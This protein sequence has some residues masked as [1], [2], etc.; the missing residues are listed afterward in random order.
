MK[1]LLCALCLF[2]VTPL[3]QG[4]TVYRCGA[5]GRSYSQQPCPD[6]RAV[7]VDDPRTPAQ[8]EQ[9][10]DA[11]RRDARAAESL[12]HERRRGEAVVV[13][14]AGLSAPLPKAQGSPATD[15]PVKRRAKA[16]G[17]K[18]ASDGEFRAIGP[19]DPAV[20]KKSRS[21]SVGSPSS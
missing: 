6:G 12:A 19:A 21:K 11:V 15:K 17:S 5:D 2:A 1:P 13:R 3:V 14:A 4:E 16:H 18:T 20:R 7:G 10:A 9:A 8:R